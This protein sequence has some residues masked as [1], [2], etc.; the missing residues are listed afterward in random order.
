MRRAI[1]TLVSVTIFL[2]MAFVWTR[3]GATHAGRGAISPPGEPTGKLDGDDQV[4]VIVRDIK[5]V[6][7]DEPGEG[8]DAIQG[9]P[10]SMRFAYVVHFDVTRV[11]KGELRG[12]E[13][14]I[15]VHSPS[16]DLG[17]RSGSQRGVLHRYRC[18]T[19]SHYQFAPD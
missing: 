7:S 6:P 8:I 1:L 14:K 3:Q 10:W 5:I 13:L 18:A 17:V 4:E 11:L 12:R 9:V 15:L 19:G 2:A 16:A